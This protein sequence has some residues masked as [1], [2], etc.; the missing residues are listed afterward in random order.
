M[1]YAVACERIQSS[2]DM[3]VAEAERYFYNSE[4]KKCIKLLDE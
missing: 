1:P 2:L 4:Y 3:R